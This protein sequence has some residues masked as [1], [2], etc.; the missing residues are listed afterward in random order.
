M[1]KQ[2]AMDVPLTKEQEQ[3]AAETR[4]MNYLKATIR[5]DPKCNRSGC[6]NGTD[7]FITFTG[8][9]GKPHLK[10]IHCRCAEIGKSEFA[11]VNDR[12][13]VLMS[14]IAGLKDAATAAIATARKDL[15]Y[16]LNVH[17]ETMSNQI[18]ES[19]DLIYRRTILGNLE[20]FGEWLHLQWMR[21]A[22]KLFG[23]LKNDVQKSE[24]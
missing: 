12:I 4:L 9:D 6:K 24:C 7:S 13:D 8:D 23:G 16:Q 18:E 5:P 15:T 19:K 11:M 21:L 2:D 17:H 3:F 22:V 14:A 1:N 10:L 20:R